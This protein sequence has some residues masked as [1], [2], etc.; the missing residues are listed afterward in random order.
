[1]TILLGPQVRVQDHQQVA[2]GRCLADWR[3]GGKACGHAAFE[4]RGKLKRMCWLSFG[5]LFWG[6]FVVADSAND[7]YHQYFGTGM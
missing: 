5:R 1:M 6:Q 3:Q 4:G 7:K 2:G